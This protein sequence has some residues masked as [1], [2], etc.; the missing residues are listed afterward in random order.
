MKIVN[1]FG[2]TSRAG[3]SNLDPEHPADAEDDDRLRRGLRSARWHPLDFPSYAAAP[4]SGRSRRRESR[5]CIRP[6]EFVRCNKLG[7]T[8]YYLRQML[9]NSP[10]FLFVFLPATVAAYIVVPPVAG[11]PAVLAVVG[12]PPT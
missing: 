8:L 5:A 10:I 6:I 2:S 12:V 4:G 3:V 7:G 11:T 9:F 1:K